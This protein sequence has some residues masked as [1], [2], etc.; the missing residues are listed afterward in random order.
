MCFSY[1]NHEVGAAHP[2]SIHPEKKLGMPSA[3][4]HQVKLPGKAVCWAV[5][6][7]YPV[8]KNTSLGRVTKSTAEHRVIKQQAVF[9]YS[10]NS[11]E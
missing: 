5:L 2:V 10:W 6:A 8:P 9:G 3:E 1:N 4:E 11:Q 7:L